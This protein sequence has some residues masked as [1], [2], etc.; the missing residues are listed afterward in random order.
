MGEI[1]LRVSLDST[2]SSADLFRYF[3]DFTTTNEWDPNTVKT[4][5]L[6]GDGGLGSTYSNTSKFNGKESS[7]VYEVIEHQPNSLIKLRGEN[8]NI[9]AIDTMTITDNGNNRTFTYEARFKL[10]GLGNLISPLLSKAFK[11]LADEAEVG[12]RKVI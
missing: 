1:V 8:K 6:T 10:K 3:A 11:K 12:L 5:L 2:K 9:V 7:L 4:T